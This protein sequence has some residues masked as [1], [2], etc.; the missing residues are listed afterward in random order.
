LIQGERIYLRPVRIIDIP[1]I[2]QWE[3]NPENWIV[4]ETEKAYTFEEINLLVD[5]SEDIFEN[6]QL[7]LMIILKSVYEP[8][9]TLDLFQ[10]VIEDGTVHV[11]ILIADAN[12]RRNGYA[13]E[14]IRLA[15][16]YVFQE[17]KF[18]NL[19]CSVQSFNQPSLELF[20]KCGFEVLTE[21]KE[22]PIFDQNSS[23]TILMRLCLKK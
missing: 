3:N 14:A 15:I 21:G 9:G 6:G 2:M 11:G 5:S 18:E 16:N 17:L 23:E 19:I 7:R 1:L 10:A 4:S 20:K 12:K 8:I 22:N 13:E